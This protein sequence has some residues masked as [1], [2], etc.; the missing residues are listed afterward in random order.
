MPTVT[1]HRRR[2]NT[3]IALSISRSR[4]RSSKRHKNSTA[5][6]SSNKTAGAGVTIVA[7]AEAT[8]ATTS[9]PAT[10]GRDCR[11]SSRDVPLRRSVRAAAAPRNATL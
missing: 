4:R 9:P 1:C 6:A 3:V 8:G 10:R 2:H 11:S 7:D 5:S